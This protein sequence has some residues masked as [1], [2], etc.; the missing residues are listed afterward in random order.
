[1]KPS[2]K[3]L[4]QFITNIAAQLANLHSN[5]FVGWEEI[6]LPF[7]IT[8]D[9]DFDTIREKAAELNWDQLKVLQIRL[10]K[11]VDW[12]YLDEQQTIEQEHCASYNQAILVLLEDIKQ[13]PK[14][15][16]EKIKIFIS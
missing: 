5:S 1:M 16:I 8:D 11:Y 3:I 7:E 10:F 15:Y 9:D 13:N 6:W 2:K 14:E 4:D 12:W